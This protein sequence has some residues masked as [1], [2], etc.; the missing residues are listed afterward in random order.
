M[1]YVLN[2]T[3]QD[4]G[5]GVTRSRLCCPEPEL[6]SELVKSANSSTLNFTACG[7]LQRLTRLS[8]CLSSRLSISTVAAC[9]MLS[10]SGKQPA[11][12]KLGSL[13]I[14]E[15]HLGMGR[16]YNFLC[17]RV[18]FFSNIFRTIASPG[19]IRRHLGCQ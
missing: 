13:S 2:N 6:E 9:A 19:L 3:N 16:R 1:L 18:T 12:L 10:I 14:R 8:N 17:T 5:V 7:S 11:T 4:C 15:F